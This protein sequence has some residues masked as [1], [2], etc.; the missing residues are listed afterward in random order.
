MSESWVLVD[1]Y[2]VVHA[3]PKL[4][5]PAG[6]SLE[7]RRAALLS[8]LAQYADQTGRRV[9][10]VFDGSAAKHKP[11][12]SQTPAG[13]EVLFSDRGKTADEVIERLVAQAAH[14][15][16]ILVITSD[17]LERQM[18]E[19]LGAWSMSADAF[20]VEVATALR[21]LAQSVRQHS[22]PRRLGAVRE[23]FQG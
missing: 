13:L 18:V 12:D 21:D 19:N 8:L 23:R 15:P 10:V 22:R 11:V 6:R 4:V 7:N 2:N 1:G 9:T 17:S 16:Q 5:K 14:R 20:A 3:W